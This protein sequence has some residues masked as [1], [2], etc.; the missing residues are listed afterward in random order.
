[1]TGTDLANFACAFSAQRNNLDNIPKLVDKIN[2][3]VK[4]V[5]NATTPPNLI[6]KLDDDHVLTNGEVVYKNGTKRRVLRQY[7]SDSVIVEPK[8]IQAMGDSVDM[9][10]RLIDAVALYLMAGIETGRAPIYMGMF[11]TEIEEFELGDIES[12]LNSDLQ[13]AVNENNNP[14]A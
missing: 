3:A 2:I 13:P 12:L 11:K 6:V 5:A 9:H 4:K 14:L 7:S 8:P 1:M 10:F